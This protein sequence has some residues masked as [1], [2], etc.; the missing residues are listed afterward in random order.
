MIVNNAHLLE[1]PDQSPVGEK[2]RKIWLA[3]VTAMPF[4]WSVGRSLSYAL[5]DYLLEF[6]G[7]GS[8]NP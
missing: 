6:V 8:S 3:D 7:P 1:E 5:W 4:N 2:T